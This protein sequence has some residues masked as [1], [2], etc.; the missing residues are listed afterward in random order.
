MAESIQYLVTEHIERHIGPVGNVYASAADDEPE[1]RIVHVPPSETRPVHTLITAGMS[2]RPMKV[3][4]HDAP[5]RLELMMTLPRTWQLGVEAPTEEQWAWPIE[6]LRKLA[7]RAHT[8]GGWLGW[9]HI[10]PN[11]EPPKPYARST[12]QCAALIV[13]SLLV[14]TAF[15]EL[16]TPAD[17][18]IVFYAVVP[19]YNEEYEL[20]RTAGTD[21]LFRRLIDRDFNDVVDPGRR[22]AAKKRFWFF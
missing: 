13:P 6:L 5:T 19:I 8:P 22:N 1:V 21:A 14:P 9:G 10:V 16:K 12:R 2:E 7:R 4:K 11:E 17:A 15:Y 3:S 18:S 20:G